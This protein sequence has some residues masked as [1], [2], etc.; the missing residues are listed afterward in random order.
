MYKIRGAQ[1]QSQQ[2]NFILWWLIFLGYQH[3]FCLCNFPGV[4][5]I[6]VVPGLLDILC[7]FYT[8][9]HGIIFH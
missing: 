3:G 2:A 9:L 7:T 4:Q 6:G 5:N 1:D 8:N